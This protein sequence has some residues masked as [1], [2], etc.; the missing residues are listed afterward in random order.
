[1]EEFFLE[2]GDIIHIT[3]KTESLN[4]KEFFIE[5]IDS[6]HIRIANKD[7]I[8][9]IQLEEDGSF[10]DLAITTVKKI[11]SSLEKGFALQKGLVTGKTIKIEFVQEDFPDIIGIITN[12]EN[13]RIE[14]TL[15]SEDKIYIDFEYKGM[16]LFVKHI[17]IRNIPTVELEPDLPEVG[18]I[19]ILPETNEETP[20]IPDQAEIIKLLR[21]QY[22]IPTG[23]I[24]LGETRNITMR[25]EKEDRFLTH[26]IEAQVTDIVDSLLSTIPN[27]QRTESVLAEVHHLVER[28]KQLRTTFSQT[29]EHGS[30]ICPSTYSENNKPLATLITSGNSKIPKWILPVIAA[31]RKTY[32]HGDK[33][34]NGEDIEASIS[35][36]YKEQRDYYKNSNIRDLPF[37]Q[38]INNVN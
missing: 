29:D 25:V 10:S 33:E 6:K 4:G 24:T 15:E 35:G 11:S 37:E 30:I 19:D 38:Y 20:H 32:S 23:E 9:E 13:D 1:M 7:G 34:D 5:Y 28:Y 21:E 22:I 8:R 17:T 12:L 26:S 14:I 3:A 27:N 18:N 2:Y 31:K 36:E 16:P